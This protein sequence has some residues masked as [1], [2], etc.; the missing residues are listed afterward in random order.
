[1]V[2]LSK[3]LYA[4]GTSLVV[5]GG[6]LGYY[7]LS[8]DTNSLNVQQPEKEDNTTLSKDVIQVTQPVDHKDNAVVV[9]KPSI[10]QV[11]PLNKDALD[12]DIK[13][14]DGDA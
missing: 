4:G 7:Y 1:M 5:G 6:G 2:N 14:S 11:K 8:G 9:T 12:I 13:F 10:D 3:I